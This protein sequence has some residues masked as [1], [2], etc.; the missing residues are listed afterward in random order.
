MPSQDTTLTGTEEVG[1]EA[2]APPAACG[3]QH[4]TASSWGFKDTPHPADSGGD[5]ARR[6]QQGGVT[7]G[8]E[9]GAR[10][11]RRDRPGASP[12]PARAPRVPHG[13][14]PPRSPTS[15]LR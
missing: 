7:W 2:L 1:R 11:L 5:S 3:D 14:P 13:L 10:G 15:A 12:A 8:S 4:S 6:V 9:P